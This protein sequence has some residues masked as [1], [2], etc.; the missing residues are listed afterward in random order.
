MATYEKDF[1][2]WTQQQAAFL[3]SG[4]FS[5]IDLENLIEEIESMGRSEKRE[6]ESRLTILLMHLLKWQYQPAYRGR[7]WELTIDEQ[8]LQF[9]KVLKDNPG[10]KN[11][12]SEMLKDAYEIAVIKAAKET[13]LDKKTFPQ[14]CPWEL[15]KITKND[16]YPE[17]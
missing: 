5:E 6:L 7:S 17:N 10:L 14:N 3:K 2:T 11:Q 4:Q 12:L 15:D 9:L 13:K 8:R 1:Y 16:F